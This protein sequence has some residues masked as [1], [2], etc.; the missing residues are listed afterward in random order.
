MD[1]TET[2]TVTPKQEHN[3]NISDTG[4]KGVKIKSVWLIIKTVAGENI[5]LRWAIKRPVVFASL[6]GII[7]C[8]LEITYKEEK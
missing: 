3:Y 2:Y 7:S 4:I 6:Q 1:K 5:K 8:Y